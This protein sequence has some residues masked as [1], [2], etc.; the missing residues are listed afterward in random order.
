M[1]VDFIRYPHIVLRKGFNMNEHEQEFAVKLE[2][3][4]Q[5]MVSV[6]HRLKDLE[7]D[8]KN[9]MDLTISVN[10]L[11]S[12]ME[13]ML[14]EQQEQGARLKVLEDEPIQNWVTL[15][16]TIITSI[17]SILIGAVLTLIIK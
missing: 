3:H 12:N 4:E 16:R 11:A 8:S 13:R 17:V 1:G 6:E 9:I 10:T 2:N 15:K 5:R 7:M 14:T